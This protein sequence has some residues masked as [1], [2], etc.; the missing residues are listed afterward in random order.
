MK[1]I[2][3][4]QFIVLLLFCVCIASC[5]STKSATSTSSNNTNN[6]AKKSDTY[7]SGEMTNGTFYIL[8]KSNNNALQPYQRLTNIQLD[9]VPLEKTAMQRW[10]VIQDIDQKTKKLLNTYTIISTS[11]DVSGIYNDAGLVMSKVNKKTH[12]Q[13]KYNEEKKAYTIWHKG[14]AMHNPSGGGF[15]KFIAFDENNDE[16][17]FKFMKAE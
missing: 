4:S 2:L 8:C 11:D 7:A 3:K 5:Q 15:T 17:F 13:I 14:D 9:D 1:T 12:I 16:F 10:K 6:N